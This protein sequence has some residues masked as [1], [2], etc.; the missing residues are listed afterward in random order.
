MGIIWRSLWS[1]PF[2]QQTTVLRSLNTVEFFL[3]A[4]Q[5]DCDNRLF[6]LWKRTFSRQYVIKFRVFKCFRQRFLLIIDRSYFSNESRAQILCFSSLSRVEQKTQKASASRLCVLRP[7]ELKN[8]V[9]DSTI[10]IQSYHFWSQFQSFR[11]CEDRKLTVYRGNLC[12]CGYRYISF[13]I[14]FLLIIN[15]YGK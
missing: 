8:N 3:T 14:F 5:A 2:K 15:L 13:G 6:D 4:C 9:P 7:I 1:W 11:I 10:R 12:S